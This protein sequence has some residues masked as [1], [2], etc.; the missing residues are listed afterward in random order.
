M[1]PSAADRRLLRMQVWV[2]GVTAMVTLAFVLIAGIVR[3][4]P[5][6]VIAVTLVVIAVA[7][8]LGFRF[9]RIA[10]TRGRGM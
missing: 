1:E 3:G 10:Y 5:P 6:L 4:V 2:M 9:G 7:L 8:A